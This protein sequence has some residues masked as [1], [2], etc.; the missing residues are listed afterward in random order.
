VPTGIHGFDAIALGGIPKGRTTLIAGTAGSGKTIFAANWLAAGIMTYDEPG[1]F[2][3]FEELAQDIVRDTRGFGWG[4]ETWVD[5]GKWAFVDVSFRDIRDVIIAGDFDLGAL[6][7]RIKA[8]AERIGAKRVALD[9]ISAIFSQLKDEFR[10]RNELLKITGELQRY[11]M[12]TVMTAERLEEYG[13]IARFG[14]EEYIADNVVILRNDLRSMRRYR[15]IE[16]LK[17]RG[18]KHIR[19][20]RPFIIQPGEGIYVMPSFISV[21]EGRTAYTE[22]RV[23][24]GVEQLNEMTGGGVYKG[25]IILISGATGTGKTLLTSHF[26]EAGI[27]NGEKCLIFALEEGLGQVLR[28]TEGWDM[29]FL[30]AQEEGL[31]HIESFYPESNSAQYHLSRIQHLVDE[32][33]P[34]RIALDSLSAL[35]RDLSNKDFKDFLVALTSFIRQKEITLMVTSSTPK[36][37]NIQ[38]VTQANISTLTDVIFLLRYIE[39]DGRVGRGL[40]VLKMRGSAHDKRLWEFT[41]DENGMTIGEP[42]HDIEGTL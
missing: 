26:I 37:L 6:V 10:I 35:Q 9:S 13:V 30:S 12:T 29:D 20:E 27:E 15:T 5:E 31:L 24:L 2:V 23:N 39:M 34:E 4:I 42:V 36:L 17:F 14:V 19:G 22:E 21:P 25:S 1:V 16:I 40:T 7:A 8:A 11:G 41:I 3:T 28:N 33:E 38:T 18:A 32:F